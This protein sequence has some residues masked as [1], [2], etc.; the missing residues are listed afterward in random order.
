M[1]PE[2][3]GEKRRG[4]EVPKDILKKVFSLKP[5]SFSPSVMLHTFLPVINS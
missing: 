2:Q 4:E 3:G 5:S 1:S